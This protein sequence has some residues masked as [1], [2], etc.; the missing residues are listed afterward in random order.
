MCEQLSAICK[1]L[2]EFGV[3]IT[4]TAYALSLTHETVL[5]IKKHFIYSLMFVGGFIALAQL[6]TL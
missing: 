6:K 2:P 5:Y 3:I 1:Q 4:D